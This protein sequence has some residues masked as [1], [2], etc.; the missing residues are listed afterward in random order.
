MQKFSY[1]LKYIVG[2]QNVAADCPSQRYNYMHHVSPGTVEKLL[3]IAAVPV[4][5]H[6]LQNL[7]PEYE[8][9]ET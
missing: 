1:I 4:Q 6:S 2:K 7:I 5:K 9:T 8:R 3:S